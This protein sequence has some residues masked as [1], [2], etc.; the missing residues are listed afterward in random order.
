MSKAYLQNSSVKININIS[1]LAVLIDPVSYQ[2]IPTLEDY[3]RG[4]YLRYLAQKR[5]GQTYSIVEI[6]QSTYDDLTKYKQKYNY[7]TWKAIKLFWQLTGPKRDNK[8]NKTQV[9]AGIEDTNIRLIRQQEKGF[10]GLAQ[11]LRDPLQYA[12]ITIPA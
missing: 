7:L 6:D 11:Y 12:R 1:N 10:P 3:E 4:Y 9:V 8:T 2:A 5:K